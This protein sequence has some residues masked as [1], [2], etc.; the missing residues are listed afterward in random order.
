[1]LTQLTV[2]NLFE[3]IIHLVIG[4]TVELLIASRY[5]RKIYLSS[6]CTNDQLHST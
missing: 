6:Y 4:E 1:M 3:N 2:I 5:R